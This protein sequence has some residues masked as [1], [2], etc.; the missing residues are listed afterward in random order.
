MEKRRFKSPIP[1]QKIRDR[2]VEMVAQSGIRDA[3]GDQIRVGSVLRLAS[4][5]NQCP[6][7]AYDPCR[8]FGAPRYC[9]G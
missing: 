1:R 3:Y 5:L 2:L 8:N 4:D 7:R 6:A 9:V